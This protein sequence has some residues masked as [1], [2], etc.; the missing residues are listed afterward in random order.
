M[1]VVP[2]TV[3]GLM[4]EKSVSLYH[5]N[6]LRAPL[7]RHQTEQARPRGL[8]ERQSAGVSEG[9]RL[10]EAMCGLWWGHLFALF[11]APSAL[12]AQ[13]VIPVADAHRFLKIIDCMRLQRGLIRFWTSCRLYGPQRLRS[14]RARANSDL[15][16]EPVEGSELARLCEAI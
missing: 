3:L 8:R 10:G 15:V 12:A 9:D 16:R 4:R 2:C 14:G 6:T 13:G 5:E 1:C 11:R 7:H